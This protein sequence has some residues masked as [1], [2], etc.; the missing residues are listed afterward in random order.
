M[1][2]RGV[3]GRG[4]EELGVQNELP[5]GLAS[6]EGPLPG[7]VMSRYSDSFCPQGAQSL[8]QE[9]D[10]GHTVQWQRQAASSGYT[11]Y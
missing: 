1:S 11:I 2:R 3:S 6:Q 10:R 7:M 4:W 8:E 9:V 5:Q